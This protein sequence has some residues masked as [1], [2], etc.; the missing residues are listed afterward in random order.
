MDGTGYGELR[1]RREASIWQ[2][3]NHV[4]RVL[5]FIAVWLLII[6][7]FLPPYKKLQ[8]NRAEME[9]LQAQLN[10]QQQLL[11]RQTKR[12][13]LLKTDATYLETI[14]RDSLELMK[15]GET[16]FRLETRRPAP[17]A[18]SQP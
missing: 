9:Q 10:E 3:M 2:Q 15:E 11:A 8:Q 16:I 12:V 5:L 14:A 1:A 6:S 4:L 13:A 18:R 7:F 17:V